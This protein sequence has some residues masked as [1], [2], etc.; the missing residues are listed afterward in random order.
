MRLQVSANRRHF[1]LADSGRPFFYLADTGWEL[2]HRLRREEVLHY[3]DLRAAQGFTVIQCTLLSEFAGRNEANALG[4][5]PLI[6]ADP[7]RP[8]P[9]FFEHVDW[10]LAE[11]AK[12][13]LYAGLVCAWG[14]KVFERPGNNNVMFNPA[15]ARAYG[16]FLGQRYRRTPNIIWI[17]GGDRNASGYEPV[18]RA[19]GQALCDGNAG[20]HLIT[21]HPN[22]RHSSTIWFHEDPW[23]DF[24]MIQ[25]GHNLRWNPNYEMVRADYVRPPAKPVVDGEPAYENHPVDW[26]PDEKGWF[27]DRDVRFNAYTAVFAGA[28]G[29][30]YGCHDIWQFRDPSREPVGFSRATNWRES[31]QLPGAVQMGHLRKLIESHDMLSRIPDQGALAS[32]QGFGPEYIASTRGRDYVLVYSGGRTFTLRLG[33]AAGATLKASWFDPRTGVR[34]PFGEVDNRGTREFTPP[35]KNEDWVLVLD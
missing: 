34:T 20:A 16:L 29:H 6:D 21:F 23:L 19:M 28:A 22:G 24:H 31:A 7:A 27:A 32:S 30:T 26:K 9:K 12:R 5:R 13:N 25:S 1:V 33:R 3:L 18:W 2:F 15:N 11:M 17:L 35:S 14:D 4:L 8:N 10:V